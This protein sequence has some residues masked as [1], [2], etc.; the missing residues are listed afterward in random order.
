MKITIF[1]RNLNLINELGYFIGNRPNI[2]ALQM[3]FENVVLNNH[4][5]CLVSPANSF[6]FMNGGIDGL[7]T[8]KFGQ[9][10]EDRVRGQIV[11]REIK[12]LL[13]GEAISVP[14]VDNEDSPWLIVAPTMRVPM[15]I[16][17]PIDVYLATRAAVM[18]AAKREIENLYI[19]GMGTGTGMVPFDKAA[20]AMIIG[21]ENAKK[22]SPEF[23]SC[24][25]AFFDHQKFNF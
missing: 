18:E 5:D 21:I 12:E 16:S 25:A 14:L 9:Q 11:K 15:R 22:G 3:P 7:Y 19:P 10:L 8:N 2:S 24:N 13:V 23:D 6:G 4:V 20:R 17:D 1:D